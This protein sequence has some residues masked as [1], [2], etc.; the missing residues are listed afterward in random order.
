MI[1]LE[2]KQKS[3]GCLKTSAQTMNRNVAAAPHFAT[4]GHVFGALSGVQI[5]HTISCF[6]SWEVRGLALQTVRD[7][8]V[9]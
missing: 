3:Y 6:E 9:K 8:E 1:D 4:L 2:L 5:M 7:L